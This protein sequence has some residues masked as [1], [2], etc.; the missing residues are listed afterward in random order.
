MNRNKR[1]ETRRGIAEVR[2]ADVN[3][4]PGVT[5]HCIR[6]DVVDDYG[7]LWNAH[8]FDESLARQ[9]PTL[10][11]AHNWSEP[12]GPGVEARTGDEGPEVDFTFSD[13]EAVPMARR[14]HAQV[15]D[16]TIRDCSV[17]F[18]NTQRRDPTDAERQAYPGIREVIEKA[19]LDE[20][21]LVL[22]GAVPGAKVLA[23]RTAEGEAEVS[24]DAWLEVARK[25]AAGDLTVAEGKAALALAATGEETEPVDSTVVGDG[26]G[27]AL[28]EIVDDPELDAEVDAALALLDRSR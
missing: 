28:P 5:L 12:L 21:S 3:G 13:F 19:D 25:V 16:G 9:L 18:S 23:V 26:T 17:G 24:E 4:Q 15:L 7:S 8:C 1:R 6:P 10:C 14:A 2:A 22:A 11:W 27:D 20:V